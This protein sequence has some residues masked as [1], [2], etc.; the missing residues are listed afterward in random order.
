MKNL[1]T[2]LCFTL[3]LVLTN[4]AFAVVGP[5]APVANDNTEV[6]ENV[7]P[8]KMTKKELR[9]QKKIKKFQ[10]KLRKMQDKAQ[11]VDFSDPVDKWMWFWIFGWG[12][13][14]ILSILVPTIFLSGGLGGAFGALALISLV[15][16]FGTISLI[17][18]LIK[19]FS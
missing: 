13:G 10:K 3:C 19:K 12:L 16:L 1:V 4:S 6:T 8:Q 14:L 9:K 18:W 7:I 5:A 2:L 11:G 15:W 17:I